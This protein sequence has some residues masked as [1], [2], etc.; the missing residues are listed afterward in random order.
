MEISFVHHDTY[1][2]DVNSQ[3][4]LH[5]LADFLFHEPGFLTDMADVVL[6]KYDWTEFQFWKIGYLKKEERNKRKVDLREKFAA[7]LT[8]VF[9]L[10]HQPP[11][12][13]SKESY[14]HRLR[15]GVLEVL[16]TRFLQER[17]PCLGNNCHVYVDSEPLK[18]SERA[19][20]PKTVDVAGV[21]RLNDPGKGELY[22]C[23]VSS[24]YIERH[25]LEFIKAARRRLDQKG[26]QSILVA[27]IS[28]ESEVYL[29]K[30]FKKLGFKNQKV[31]S[32]KYLGK[33]S[34]YEDVKAVLTG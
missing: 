14:L 20:N 2:D 21:D 6:Y 8:A 10:V 11:A 5:D 30:T 22:E 15:G 32:R 28:F 25:H 19:A 27:I 9:D 34:G 13:E 1:M 24:R 3:Q 4:A 18:V 16:V 7:L 31:I 29:T 17:Y 23:K 12:G 26:L 33:L